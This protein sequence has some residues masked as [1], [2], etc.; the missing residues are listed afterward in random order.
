MGM[1]ANITVDGK[2]IGI[3][4]EIGKSTKDNFKLR[5]PIVSFE[6]KLPG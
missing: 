5:E 1:L 4:G 3:I 2:V 6:I